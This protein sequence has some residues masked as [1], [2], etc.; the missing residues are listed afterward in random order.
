MLQLIIDAIRN[1]RVLAITYSGI[2]RE[3]EPHCV[4]ASRTGKDSL[5]CFQTAGGHITPG[6]EWDFITISEIT[7]IAET[8]ANFSG[9]RPGY[10]KGDRHMSTIYAEL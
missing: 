7:H 2:P 10:N 1:R 3:V 9:P 6:H 5:R 4:G 8:G